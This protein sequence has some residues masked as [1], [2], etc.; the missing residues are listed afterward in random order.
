MKKRNSKQ[1]EININNGLSEKKT[2]NTRSEDEDDDGDDDE[3]EEIEP[4]PS[5]PSGKGLAQDTSSIDVDVLNNAIKD[6][7]P[8]WR[9]WIVRGILG[10][11]M[12]SGFSFVI[13]MG[14]LALTLLILG[15]QVKC[16]QEIISIGYYVYKSHHLP[17]FRTISWLLLLSS[18]YYFYGESLIGKF[19]LLFKHDGFL[20]PFVTYHRFISYTLYMA[21]CIGFILTLRKT[22]YLKQFTLFGYT[23]LALI[24]IVVQA[25]LMIQN[26]FEGLIWFLVPACLIICNDIMAY[27]F[28]FFFGK[29]KLIKLSPKK[30]WEGFIGGAMS[31]LVFGFILSTLLCKH[32]QFVCPLQYD[33]RSDEIKFDCIPDKVFQMHTYSMPQPVAMLTQTITIEPFVLQHTLCIGLFV[34]FVGPFGGFFASGFKRAYQIKDFGDTI[35]GHGGFTDRFDCFYIT[36]GTFVNAYIHSFIKS[37]SPHK[38]FDQLLEIGHDDQEEFFRLVQN[39]FNLTADSKS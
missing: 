30:T 16:Y 6:L 27:F 9:N 8:K 3:D 36:A 24:F 26:I 1:G 29:T 14:P 19:R 11:L 5:V 4:L 7:K 17:W 2:R 38:L 22:Y 37:S 15:I 12:I 20:M 34:S 33:E 31:T 13:Y 25:N 28:G 10:C 18:N 32:K 39:H 23:H 21:S 35:P